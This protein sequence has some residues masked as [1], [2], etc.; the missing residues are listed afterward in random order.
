LS[1]SAI[2]GLLFELS[3]PAQKARTERKMSAAA[4]VSSFRDCPN[5]P[6]MVTVPAGSFQMG[7]SELEA[8][9]FIEE[10]PQH[11]IHIKSFAASRFDVTRDEW[12]GLRQ[13]QLASDQHGMQV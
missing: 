2:H 8:K 6:E 7:A 9:G 10:G 5:C 3:V 13:Y 4:K 1:F 12:K 11:P